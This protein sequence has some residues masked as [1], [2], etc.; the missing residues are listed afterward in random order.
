MNYLA[1]F[2]PNVLVGIHDSGYHEVLGEMPDHSDAS[3]WTDNERRLALVCQC[4]EAAQNR[5]AAESR[6]KADYPPLPDE[7][8]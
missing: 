2:G 6:F 8:L 4:I 1:N 5:A 3:E 7:R